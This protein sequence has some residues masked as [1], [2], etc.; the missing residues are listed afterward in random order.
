[1][2]LTVVLSQ[3]HPAV[4][5][6]VG[7]YSQLVKVCGCVH[8]QCCSNCVYVCVCGLVAHFWNPKFCSHIKWHRFQEF[9]VNFCRTLAAALEKGAGMS[10]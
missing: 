3:C 4:L 9:F 1:M 7:F 10:L 2:P 6:A 8:V 5:L